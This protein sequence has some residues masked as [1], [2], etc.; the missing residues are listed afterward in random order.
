MRIRIRLFAQA[1]DLAGRDE[2][3]LNVPAPATVATA[4]AAL[5]EQVPALAPLL[6]VSRLA[7]DA[8][9]V[10]DGALLS[11]G[12]ELALIPPVSGG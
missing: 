6:G 11:D 8:E 1:R 2:L 10:V 3:E 12:A 4:R 9:Y 7:L 5:A